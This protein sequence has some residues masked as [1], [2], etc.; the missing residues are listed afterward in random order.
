MDL[1]RAS[2]EM[3][4]TR[5][6]DPRPFGDI[7]SDAVLNSIMALGM[8][9]GFSLLFS[10]LTE[11]F[12]L[13]GI[14]DVAAT[15]IRQVFHILS[16]PE[17]LALPLFSRLFEITIGANMISQVSADPF[18][19]NIT[20]ISFILGFHGFSIQAQVGSIIAKS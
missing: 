4:Q 20:L 15:F 5:L 19:A 14:P 18:L 10:V 9:G 1:I 2:K 16:I 13:M 6:E 8:L 3:H 12:F 11:L 17:A 7:F